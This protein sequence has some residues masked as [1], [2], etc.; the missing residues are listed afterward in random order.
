MTGAGLGLALGLALALTDGPAG[1]YRLLAF[2]RLETRAGTVAVVPL[3]DQGPLLDLLERLGPQP[4]A[5]TCLLPTPA[6]ARPG[7]ARRVAALAQANLHCRWVDT[8]TAAI[9]ACQAAPGL[10]CQG[11]T[12]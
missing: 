2:G 6:V 4:Q 5:L 8:L 7:D 10:V 1:G 9:R 11:E 12:Q 3:T